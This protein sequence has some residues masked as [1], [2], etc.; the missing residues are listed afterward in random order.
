M[1]RD[2]LEINILPPIRSIF[3]IIFLPGLLKRI[4]TIAVNNGGR[5]FPWLPISSVLIILHIGFN[6]IKSENDLLNVG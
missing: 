4:N 1:V 3:Y 5:A 6:F 2:E